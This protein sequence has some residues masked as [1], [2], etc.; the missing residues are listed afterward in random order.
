MPHG[1]S[2]LL[3]WWRMRS[4]GTRT[5]RG[6]AGRAGRLQEIDADRRVGLEWAPETELLAD[7][8]QG[9][10]HLGAEQSDARLGVL[11]GHEA[12]GGPEPDDRRPRL[13]QQPAQ[14]GDDRLRR[15]GDDLL[16]AELVLQRRRP[17]IRPPADRELYE[18]RAIGR[19]EV[20]GRARPHRVRQA[21]ELALHPHEL[22]RVGQRLLLGLGHVAALQVAAIL[23]P[24]LVADLG[25][26]LVVE[27]PD[28]LGRL[29]LRAERDVGIAL[30][31]G[32]DDRLLA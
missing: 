25:R 18:R 8:T 28:A 19:R 21:G 23:G 6:R 27:L 4:A 22:P 20:A 30:A 5:L 32:P 1:R 11:V 17:R 16:V 9:R 13:F 31:R 15:A 29:D 24:A 12:V 14:L 10:Q 7:L 2:T 26:R 3:S